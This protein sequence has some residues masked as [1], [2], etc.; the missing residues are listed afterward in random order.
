MNRV[1]RS[2]FRNEDGMTLIEIMIVLAIMAAVM[3]GV[4]AG[5]MPALRN[6]KVE[7]AKTAGATVLTSAIIYAEQNRGETP[8]VS[9]LVSNGLLNESQTL[10]PWNKEYSIEG[11]GE[12][13]R[14]VSGGPDGTMGGDDDVTIG[15]DE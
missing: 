7:R 4:M 8:S 5:I 12:Q 10:D 3:G 14:V 9:D 11:S 6:S 1:S 15:G 13:M 2:V